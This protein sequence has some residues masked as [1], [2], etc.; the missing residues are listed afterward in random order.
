MT[1]TYDM[2]NVS[3]GYDAV[4][5]MIEVPCGEWVSVEDHR[6]EIDRLQRRETEAAILFEPLAEHDQAI[7]EW[8]EETSPS[9][10]PQLIRPESIA[11]A[12]W[13]AMVDRLADKDRE[14]D[15]LQAS[16]KN[17]HRLLC[18]RF[19][20]GHDE[21]DWERDQL[22]LIEWIAKRAT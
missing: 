2:Q 15:R 22:S 13:D 7:R 5:K 11:S 12:A 8:L 3:T 6:A 16:F 18:E 4:Y 10:E 14:I 20:Y 17:F 21:V 1:K 9:A 19:G